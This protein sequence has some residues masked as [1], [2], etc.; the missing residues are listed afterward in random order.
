VRRADNLTAL[1]CRLS[2]NPG[3]LTSR[4]PQGH[5]VLFWGYFTLPL[6][7]LPFDHIKIQTFPTYAIITVWK[8]QQQVRIQYTYGQLFILLSEQHNYIDLAYWFLFNSTTCFSQ[9]WVGIPVHEKSKRGRSLFL[10]AVGIR[11]LEN[12]WLLFQKRN[13]MIILLSE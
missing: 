10:Q 6:P 4:N 1:M 11:L 3:A 8:V 7:Y 5:I 12:L 13:N 9:Q 2:R